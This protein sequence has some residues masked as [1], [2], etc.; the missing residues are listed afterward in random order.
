M[1]NKALDP[2]VAIEQAGR[3][4][5]KI[6]ILPDRAYEAMIDWEEM[7]QSVRDVEETITERNR[8]TENQQ[9][10]LDNWEEAVDR[11]SNN[12]DD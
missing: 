4:C 12:W 5:D 9:R 1:S 10:A 8:V 7:R 3:I 2:D 6:D 11:W